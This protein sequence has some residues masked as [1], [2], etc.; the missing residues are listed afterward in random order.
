MQTQT[1]PLNRLQADSD[2]CRVPG[3]S[4]MTLKEYLQ[5]KAEGD[6]VPPLEFIHL[7]VKL[8]RVS[9]CLCTWHS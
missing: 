3:T 8:L 7:A 4:V 2:L 9:V 1:L 6:A 5:H